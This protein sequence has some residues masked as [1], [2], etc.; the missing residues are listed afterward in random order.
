MVGR[1][2][3]VKGGHELKMGVEWRG[4]EGV[5]EL[6]M[7]AAPPR[8]K[9]LGRKVSHF[10]CCSLT[11][12][13]R[14]AKPKEE[15]RIYYACVCVRERGERERGR[16]RGER[17]RVLVV[18]FFLP[19]FTLHLQGCTHLH[20]TSFARAQ[21][22][23]DKIFGMSLS[24]PKAVPSVYLLLFSEVNFAAKF[25]HPPFEPFLLGQPWPSNLLLG[26]P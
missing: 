24:L 16:E 1:D 20:A 15:K 12:C 6:Q 14:I 21:S 18:P 4:G 26:L 2:G 7:A 8:L 5:A 19:S 17:E 3:G 13:V 9:N 25:S 23:L 11:L 10:W 22:P